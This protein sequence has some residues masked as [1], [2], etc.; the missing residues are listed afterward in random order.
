MNVLTNISLKCILCR[1]NFF[2]TYIHRSHGGVLLDRHSSSEMWTCM[3][4]LIFL[5]D[6]KEVAKTCAKYRSIFHVGW[7]SK[8]SVG[9]QEIAPPREGDGAWELLLP[10]AMLGDLKHSFKS[11]LKRDL[12]DTSKSFRDVS[13]Q[14]LVFRFI[15]CKSMPLRRRIFFV[16]LLFLIV[17]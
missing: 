5:T 14:F 7:G 8:N 17:G 11:E 12:S 2:L 4:I 9:L 16:W 6:F 15:R 3:K 13:V 10:L 1:E